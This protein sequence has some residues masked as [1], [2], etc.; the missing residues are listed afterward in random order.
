VVYV[1]NPKVRRLSVFDGHESA[2]TKLV[3]TFPKV[4]GDELTVV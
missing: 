3:A 4:I 1:G 2:Y